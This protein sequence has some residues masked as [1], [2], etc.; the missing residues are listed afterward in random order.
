ML[1]GF[2]NAMSIFIYEALCPGDEVEE[3]AF[4][5]WVQKL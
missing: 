4:S 2:I 1:N 5:T 3:V